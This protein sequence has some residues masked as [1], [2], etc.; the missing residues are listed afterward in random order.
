[1]KKLINKVF[2]NNFNRRLDSEKAV[3]II[4]NKVNTNNR[5]RYKFKSVIWVQKQLIQTLKLL[6]KKDDNQIKKITHSKTLKQ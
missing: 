3:I 6:L 5:I 1:M 2:N 4:I